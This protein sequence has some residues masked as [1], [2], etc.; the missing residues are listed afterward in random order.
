MS[1]FQER[2][3]TLQEVIDKAEVYSLPEIATRG[4]HQITRAIVQG[5]ITQ[6]GKISVVI[7]ASGMANSPKTIPVSVL[8][9][10][11]PYDIAEKIQEELSDDSDVLNFFNI[12]GVGVNLEL[13]CKQAADN[14]T[15]INLALFK[16]TAEGLVN[17]PNSSD[18]QLG[19]A[20]DLSVVEAILDD[21]LRAVRWTP[22]GEV[23]SGNRVLPATDNGRI[24][25]VVKGGTFSNSEPFGSSSFPEKITDGSVV[26]ED[27]GLNI[28]GLYDV[29][30]AIR[31]C[32]EVKLAKAAR[33][34]GTGSM[35][36][37]QIFQNCKY[38]SEY[39]QDLLIA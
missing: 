16:G 22:G 20:P 11:L 7:T 36:M 1:D 13:A 4:E 6:S 19:E 34:M 32:W 31:Q 14:D 35:S 33:F 26:L 25:W 15:T 30:S 23:R 28:G 38:M 21:C 39:Y 3:A 2:A 9:D 17:S 18:I 24:Y 10:D 8:E 37:T 12:G 5:I 29:T 27:G